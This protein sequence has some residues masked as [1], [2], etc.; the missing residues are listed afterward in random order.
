MI[1]LEKYMYR[2]P[3]CYK[4]YYVDNNKVCNIILQ[5]ATQCGPYKAQVTQYI[6]ESGKSIRIKLP[7]IF[8]DVSSEYSACDYLF[9]EILNEEV[10]KV[11]QF[12]TM[13]HEEIYRELLKIGKKM[14]IEGIEK[15]ETIMNKL[16]DIKIIKQNLDSLELF[17]KEMEKSLEHQGNEIIHLDF[18]I[19][20]NFKILLRL[21][22]FFDVMLDSTT[23]VWFQAHL[24]KEPFVDINIDILL[25]LLSVAWGRY[26]ELEFM[27]L[28]IDKEKIMF[29]RQNMRNRPIQLSSNSQDD[30]S[31]KLWKP[32]ETFL[33]CTTKY[34]VHP[35]NVVAAKACIV[36][37]IPYLIF[38]RSNEELETLL[39]PYKCVKSCEI[40]DPK[41]I[42]ESQVITSVYLDNKSTQCYWN[43]IIRYEKAQLLRLRCYGFNSGAKDMEIFIER[44]THHE[45]WTGEKSTKERFSLPQSY[46]FPYLKGKLSIDSLINQKIF[47]KK[48]ITEK[49]AKLAKEMQEYIVENNLQPFVR[50]SYLRAAF[51]HQDNNQIRFSIDTNLCM[52][53]EYI[54]N[55]HQN[56]PWCRLA[57]E[58]LS[59]NEVTRF[60]YAILEVKLQTEQPIWV[61]EMLKR[62]SATL[63]YKFS[64]FQHGMAILHKDKV[65]ILPH[66]AEDFEEEKFGSNFNSNGNPDSKKYIDKKQMQ[67]ENFLFMNSDEY[68][69]RNNQG[70]IL[71]IEN[72][73]NSY[74][75]IRIF[76]ALG[77][78]IQWNNTVDDIEYISV[79]NSPNN[80]DNMIFEKSRRIK[81]LDPKSLFAAERVFLYWIQKS[82]YVLT[83]TIILLT[84]TDNII[85]MSK[86]TK[87][88]GYFLTPVIAFMMFYGLHIYIYRCKSIKRR[89]VRSN[90]QEEDRIDHPKGSIIIFSIICSILTLSLFCS[91]YCGINTIKR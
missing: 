4:S 87:Y 51:Q 27:I 26:R 77:S 53:N 29:D 79:L 59:K 64:K 82:L 14:R 16:D 38:G 5:L 45:S 61:S 72:L 78:Q 8:P 55:G 17:L 22:Q 58:V 20:T 67:C 31:S 43:R 85:V 84:K 50:T 66:W 52:V 6:R 7:R 56:E 35:N 83:F 74:S 37:Y 1:S 28:N 65:P 10:A 86:F 49:T 75:S 76:D 3:S 9:R 21:G 89:L 68:R 69:K 36:R 70:N 54:P 23:N 91:I 39:D 81:K 63:V 57:E 40:V 19:R 34:W 12:S 25:V 48:Y 46:V 60:P 73:T 2:A 41:K 18:Y 90:E 11:N 62:C 33:R 13:K 80:V 32:P 44:K 24:T 47:D 71:N 15:L 88:L 30:K 42:E